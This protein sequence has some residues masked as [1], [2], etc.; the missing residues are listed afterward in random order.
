MPEDVRNL[1]QSVAKGFAVL[2]AFEVAEAELTITEV[3]VHAGL[4]RGAA[5]RFLHTLVS[6]GY[7]AAVPGTRRFRLTLKCLELG[8]SALAAGGLKEQAAPLLHELVPE[9]AD[10]ASLGRLDGPD[11]VYVARV[12]ADLGQRDMDRRTGSRTGAYGAALGHAIL[13]WHPAEQA[14]AVLEASERVKLSERTLVDLDALMGRLGEVRARGYAISDGENAFGLRTV[15]APVL[16]ANGAPIAGV[17]LTI[18]DER[19]A[20]DAFAAAAV[21][22]LLRVTAALSRAAAQT[23]HG[24]PRLGAA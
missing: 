23:G 19:M 20:M 15:A 1:V 8:Y 14:R 13:A 10:A 7:L 4:D 12:Q 5:F 6:L 21:P 2:R 18:R 24:V 11:V 17:S 22:P 16:D 3:A 9:E